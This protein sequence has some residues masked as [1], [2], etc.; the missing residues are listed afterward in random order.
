[1]A[2]W[3]SVKR[4]ITSHPLFVGHPERLA[5][6]IW[7]L[8]NVVWQDTRHDINGVMVVIPRGSV[9][10]SERRIAEDVGVGRQVVRTFLARLQDERMINPDLTHGRRIIS[11][12]NWEKYQSA[13]N[14]PNPPPNP[15][16]THDQ[17]I[18][19]T[20]KQVKKNTDHFHGH[21]SAFWDAYPKKVGKK[22]AE[23]KYLSAVRAG[24]DPEKIISAAKAY[25]SWQR[26]TGRGFRPELKDPTTWLN[27]EHWNDELPGARPAVDR[28]K[29]QWLL[30]QA[31]DAGNASDAERIRS[32]LQAVH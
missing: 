25:I 18:K 14:T 11:L 10:A 16:L 32:Q 26:E 15:A 9:A 29:L 7:L 23:A 12:C 24:A 28:S 27:G 19:E 3:F 22:K 20:S 5:I 13:Q 4:G 31:V 21:F 17:P 2:G 8:D 6:W 30:Q 1:M